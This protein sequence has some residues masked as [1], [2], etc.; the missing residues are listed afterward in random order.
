MLCAIWYHLYNLKNLKKTHGGVLLLVKL[1]GESCNFTK[2]NIPPWMF[3][4]FFKLYKRYQNTQLTT[5]RRY[6]KVNN[7]L[8]YIDISSNHPSQ[9]IKQLP[10]SVHKRLSQ[11][12][13]S[14]EIF[15][16]SKS[17]YEALLK[18]E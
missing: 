10:T 15:N 5:H 16:A 6:E 7:S 12:S 11:N 8:L 2:S 13:L 17:E 1:Q 9:V 18:T 4:M 14:K 3:F